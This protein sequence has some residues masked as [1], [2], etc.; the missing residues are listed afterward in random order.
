M[1]TDEHRRAARTDVSL[2]ARVRPLR[3]TNDLARRSRSLGIAVTDVS[4]LGLSFLTDQPFDI[5]DLLE[6][7]L[8]WRGV[9]ISFH[10]VVR[11]VLVRS[12]LRTVGIQFVITQSTKHAIATLK[13]WLST[14]A[15]AK[16]V[17]D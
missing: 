12:S 6:V 4:L 15:D 10:G 13:E 1:V 9:E 11:H 8:S 16:P 14:I 2:I 17:V 3:S 7:D 5:D